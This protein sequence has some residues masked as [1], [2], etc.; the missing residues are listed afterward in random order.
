[1]TIFL[2]ALYPCNLLQSQIYRFP[3]VL[4]DH[5]PDGNDRGDDEM[6]IIVDV[7]DRIVSDD[8]HIYPK[9]ADIIAVRVEN[10]RALGL[11]KA[12]LT[13]LSVMVQSQAMPNNSNA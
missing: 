3:D 6:E 13:A 8:F 5:L 1:M 2:S 9:A 11:A 12:S 4:Q 10:A 7:F